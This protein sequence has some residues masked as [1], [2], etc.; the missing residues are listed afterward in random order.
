M[1]HQK[2]KKQQPWR[3]ASG[4]DT[5]QQTQGQVCPMTTEKLALLHHIHGLEVLYT[6]ILNSKMTRATREE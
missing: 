2:R 6:R 4:L 1:K 3:Q 5:N